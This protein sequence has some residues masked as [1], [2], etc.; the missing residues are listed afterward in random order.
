[1]SR[2]YAPKSDFVVASCSWG[3]KEDVLEYMIE[4]AHAAID[5]GADVVM[6][7]GPHYSLPVEVTKASRFS[8]GLG[9]FSFHTGTADSSTAFGV[10]SARGLPSPTSGAGSDVP[11]RA[12]QRSE[13]DRRCRLA[14]RESDAR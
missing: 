2:N 7:H 3:L 11:I 12:P 4:I 10:G 9:S 8:Y 1:M 5:S 13:R 14:R 6:G